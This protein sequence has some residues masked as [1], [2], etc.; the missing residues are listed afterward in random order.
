MAIVLLWPWSWAVPSSWKLLVAY[1]TVGGRDP[2]WAWPREL[3]PFPFSGRKELAQQASSFG[4][5]GSRHWETL[6]SLVR[7]GWRQIG[8]KCE[9][10]SRWW[11]ASQGHGYPH[12][13]YER[14]RW[15][16]LLLSWDS[17]EE[18]AKLKVYVPQQKKETEAE[19]RTEREIE[20]PLGKQAA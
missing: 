8:R 5:G 19:T 13:G 9:C 18:E 4:A 16:D 6:P 14:L 15:G 1:Y 11:A 7:V 12:G 20:A 3:W 17:G 2:P 10:H